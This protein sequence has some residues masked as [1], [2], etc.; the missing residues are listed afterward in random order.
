MRL[1]CDKAL[2]R[3]AAR[4]TLSPAG[5]GDASFVFGARYFVPSPQGGEGG[6]K[7]RVRACC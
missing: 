7:R 2:T 5:R 1:A 4:A 3:L 6:A